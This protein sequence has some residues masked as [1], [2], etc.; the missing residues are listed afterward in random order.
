MDLVLDN[1]QNVPHGLSQAVWYMLLPLRL[2]MVLVV[3]GVEPDTHFLLELGRPAGLC[4]GEYPSPSR[5]ACWQVFVSG[6]QGGEELIGELGAVAAPAVEEDGCMSVR[7]LGRVDVGCW[8]FHALS[9]IAVLQFLFILGAC[10]RLPRLL[11][12]R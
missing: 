6:G 11:W 5:E 7:A 10:S 8:E 2:L 12:P 4:G 3:G 1:T 9:E